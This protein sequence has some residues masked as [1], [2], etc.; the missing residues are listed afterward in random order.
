MDARPPLLGVGGHHRH[1]PS[2]E[3]ALPSPF[4]GIQ[5]TR[6]ATG[7]ALRRAPAPTC[8]QPHSFE[9][10]ASLCTAI[11]MLKNRGMTCT[12]GAGQQGGGG[13][14]D[15]EVGVVMERWGW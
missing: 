9:A 1:G 2:S 13:G 10:S 15:G 7:H 4:A 3:A 14:G 6:S 11:D 5:P 12:A 8:T